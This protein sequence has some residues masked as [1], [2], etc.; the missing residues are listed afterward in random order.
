LD[1]GD[2]GGLDQACF[3]V[4]RT[5]KWARKP[6]DA[7]EITSLAAELS[8]IARNCVF[9]SETLVRDEELVTR[10]VRYLGQAHAIP[11]MADDTQWFANMLDAVI[12][13]ARPNTGLDEQARAFLDDIR[14]GIDT[15]IEE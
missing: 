14:Q 5:I 12:E 10:A 6:I 13:L 7:D 4:A 11:P 2:T 3:D 15:V 1:K 9:I 8:K